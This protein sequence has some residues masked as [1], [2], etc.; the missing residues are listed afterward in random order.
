[1]ITKKKFAYIL[2][3]II[4]FSISS[5]NSRAPVNTI[6]TSSVGEENKL[7]SFETKDQSLSSDIPSS[8]TLSS[9]DQV[10]PTDDPQLIPIYQFFNKYYDTYS[11][12]S[13]QNFTGVLVD[14][15]NTFLFQNYLK[16]EL[17]RQ[18]KNQ[19]RWI[20]YNFNLSNINKTQKDKDVQITVTCEIDNTYIVD[21]EKSNSSGVAPYTFTLNKSDDIW[22]ITSIAEAEHGAPNFLENFRNQVDSLTDKNKTKRENILNATKHLMDTYE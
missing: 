19:I 21:D 13:L 7:D 16:Y 6:D 14:N 1:M 18:T 2:L 12:G 15:D 4:M 5:C 17:Y 3:I 9:T 8:S 11:K 22:L 10:I 20:E